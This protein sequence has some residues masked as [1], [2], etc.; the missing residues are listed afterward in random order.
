M[1]IAVLGAGVI[2]VTTA[3]E[4]M[5]DGHEVT[6]IDRLAEAASETSF[7]NAGLFSPG[8][9]Y[10]WASPKAPKILLKSLF[11]EG[12]ALRFKP[13]LDPNLWL[14]SLKFLQNCTAE[15][16]RI[17]TKRKV[18][19]C[20][21][22][23]EQLH[24]IAAETGV[25]FHGVTGG[26]LY[27][28]RSEASFARGSANTRI[29]SEEGLEL[30]AIT[31]DE[32]AKIDPALEPVKHKFAGA[33]Y[34]PSDESG[35]AR[36][37]TRN[38][39]AYCADKGVKF[40]FNT[41]IKGF[42]LAGDKVVAVQTATGR[43]EADA[44]IFSLGVFGPALSKQLG[45]RLPIYP[46]KGYSVTMPIGGRNNPPTVGGVDEDNLVAYARFGDRM[47][48]TAT[49]EFAGFDKSHT[50]AD[51]THMLAAIKDIYPDGADYGQPNYWAGLRPMTPEGTPIF[52]TGRYTNMF[53][54]TG[55]GHIGWTMAPGSARITA[56]LVAG[57]PGALDLAGMRLSA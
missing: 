10:T 12:Q 21:Y 14:W 34:C 31:P 56:D 48:V 6:V 41:E 23:Q 42:E 52:G 20:M 57:K 44:F 39:A 1:R 47:R 36:V 11:Q 38:L 27:L 55:H 49:A 28:Y 8:H 15:K 16:T 2:G 37:F 4:L 40:Q 3:Y 22:S 26:L 35:D 7:A 50:P 32:A 33:V 13:S 30:R 46:I 5:K 24:R 43:I 45:V 25:S 53:F 18:R 29:L 51:F 19:L 9:A 54:N 17:N